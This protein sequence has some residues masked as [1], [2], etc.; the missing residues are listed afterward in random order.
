[1]A[2]AHAR[3]TEPDGRS[4]HLLPHCRRDGP[5]GRLRGGSGPRPTGRLA[6]ERPRSWRPALLPASRSVR[7]A[8]GS[9]AAPV[10]EFRQAWTVT[11]REISSWLTDMDGVLIHEGVALRGAAE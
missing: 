5:E 7:D 2:R 11:D 10:P 3:T 4:G 1:R 8:H 9:V 6:R